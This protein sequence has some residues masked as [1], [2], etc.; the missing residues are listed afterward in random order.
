MAALIMLRFILLFCVF[1]VAVSPCHAMNQDELVDFIQLAELNEGYN[2]TRQRISIFVKA[3]YVTVNKLTS[4]GKAITLE[5]FGRFA[6]RESWQ[7]YCRNPRDPWGDGIPCERWR[8]VHNPPVIGHGGFLNALQETAPSQQ[9]S[10][11]EIAR[12]VKH[13]IDAVIVQLMKQDVIESRGFGSFYV[14]SSYDTSRCGSPSAHYP[15]FRPSVFL[16]Y[17]TFV[18]SPHLRDVIRG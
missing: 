18:A 10:D 13:Y 14:I 8:A 9:Y 15:K 4:Q 3:F 6:P 16:R 11:V 7:G 1:T 2:H 5:D 12:H 17:T